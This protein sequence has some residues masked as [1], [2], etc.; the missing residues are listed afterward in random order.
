MV[1]MMVDLWAAS[2]VAKMDEIGVVGLVASMAVQLAV[3]SVDATA[4][5][6]VVLWVGTRAARSAAARA[7]AMA[8]YWAGRLAVW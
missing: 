3:T 5:E 7:A 6:T 4:G 8:V 1:A 2:L